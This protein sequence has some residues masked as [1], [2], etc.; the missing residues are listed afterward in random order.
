[1]NR[2]SA[3]VLVMGVVFSLFVAVLTIFLPD[4]SVLPTR[5]LAT[6][7]SLSNATRSATAPDGR[8]VWLV[9]GQ[10]AAESRNPVR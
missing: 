7:S 4:V 3:V 2:A 8:K 10:W 9:G 1:M 5:P 6:V